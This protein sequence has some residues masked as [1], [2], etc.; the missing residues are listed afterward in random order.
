MTP[1]QAITTL[2]ILLDGLPRDGGKILFPS[3]SENMQEVILDIIR[4]VLVQHG[5]QEFVDMLDRLEF[6]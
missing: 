5:Y 1:M 3:G 6:V 2:R 4:Q